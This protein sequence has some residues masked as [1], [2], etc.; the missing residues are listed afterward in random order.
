MLEADS[1]CCCGETCEPASHPREERGPDDCPQMQDAEQRPALLPR[2]G[3]THPRVPSTFFHALPAFQEPASMR[4]SLAAA[5]I[6][7]RPLIPPEAKNSLLAQACA[8][9]N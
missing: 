9:N 7:Y 6:A 3:L 1:G 8:L 2:S 5:R 4:S